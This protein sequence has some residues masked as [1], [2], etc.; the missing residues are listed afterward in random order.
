M[1]TFPRTE[2]E[3]VALARKVIDGL[4]RHAETYPSP[5]FTP[6][7]LTTILESFL[8]ASSEAV[9]AQAAA[10]RAV[11]NKNVLNDKLTESIKTVLRY[12][13]MTVN[14]D[15]TELKELGWGGR[16]HRTTLAVPGQPRTLQS[17][18]RDDTSIE[19]VWGEPVDDGKV[20]GYK[21][22]RRERPDGPWY[23]VD[24][25]LERSV[26]LAEQPRGKAWEY[27]VVA[28]NRAGLSVPSN[29]VQAMF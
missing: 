2:A 11:A 21:I 19:L 18:N 27:R 26:T 5:P 13:E 4:A 24:S 6:A 28:M 10:S 1:A 8:S 17:P 9:A 3:L 29:T 7:M 23:L 20:Q 25:V 22:Q 14:D 12:A 16:T 15:D